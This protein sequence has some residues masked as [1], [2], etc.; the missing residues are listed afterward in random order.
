MVAFEDILS[1][2]CSQSVEISMEKIAKKGDGSATKNKRTHV[3]CTM[4]PAIADT[5]TV[6]ALIDAGMNICR[7]NFSHGD[8]QSQGK[9]LKMVREAMEKRP[10]ANLGLLL[11]TKGPE[12]RTGLLKEHKPVTLTQGQSLKIST[13]YQMEGDNQ[14]ITCSYP[15]LPKSVSVGSTILIADGSLSCTVTETHDTYIVVKV[16]NNAT[17]GE[18]KNMNLPGVKVDLPV[19]GEKDINDIVNFAIPNNFDFIALSFSQTAD[20]IRECRR[21]LGEAGRHIK[22]IPKIENM[23][24]LSNIDEIIAEADGVMVARGD[25][26]MEI[27]IEKICLAQKYMIKR[28]N[29]AAKP[30]ITATQM[31][32]SMINFP[33][34]TRAESSD[35]VNAVLDGSD[36]VMLSGETANGKYPVDC[37][38]VMSKLCFEAESCTAMRKQFAQR[39]SSTHGPVSNEEAIARSVNLLAMELRAAAIVSLTPDGNLTRYISSCRPVCPVISCSTDPHVVKYMSVCRGVTGKRVPSIGSQEADIASALAS[40]KEVG[41]VNSGDTVIVVYE[42]GSSFATGNNCIR[43]IRA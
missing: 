13:D 5:E 37:V 10:E 42:D 9:T 16:L 41:T 8:H 25:L 22:V 28:C 34:P 14:C 6:V 15:L 21:V 4:G 7:F 26:G 17:I 35:V 36:C 23:E 32:E 40:A 12:I 3:V 43:V 1:N 38:Q 19:L 18:K 29:E 27:P 33:R 11:D 2:D 31:L 39:I 24:G 20:D 30:V